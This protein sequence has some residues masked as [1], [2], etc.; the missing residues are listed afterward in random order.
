MKVL[1]LDPN[2]A[3]RAVQPPH[4]LPQLKAYLQ[5]RT[6]HRAVLLD[7]TFRKTAWRTD[8]TRTID[9]EK[10][11]LIGISCQSLNYAQA[12][13][14][15]AFAKRRSGLPILFGGVHAILAAEEVI[16]GS[17]ADMVCTGEGERTLAN[18]LDAGLD[19]RGVRGIWYRTAAG[20][21]IRNE[22]EPVI[23]DL[24][25]LPFPDWSDYDLETYFR[26]NNHH[27]PMMCSRGCPYECTYCSA[28]ALKKAL[29]WTKVRWRSVESV[30]EEIGV[31]L[32]KYAGRGFRH[33]QFDDDTFILRREFV[34]DFCR[35][36][37]ERGYDRR[38]LWAANVR[39]DL[40]TP[41]LVS[42]MKDAGCYEV[43]LGVESVDDNVRR[44][45]YKRNMSLEQIERAVSLIRGH[46]IQLHIPIIIGSPYDTVEIMERN[47]AFAKKL[48][49]ECML[50]PALMPLPGTEIR[51][52]CEDE[53][54]IEEPGF[55]RPHDMHTRPIIRT[56]YASRRDVARILKKARRYAM[57]TYAL[58]GIRRKGLRFAWDLLA[59]LVYFKPKYLLEIDNAWKF[60]LNKYNLERAHRRRRPVVSRTEEA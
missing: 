16:A 53:G 42:A 33:L 29:G 19:P 8:L 51:K 49:A 5:E 41:E 3:G 43:G 24:D 22:P 7:F 58:E 60:T 13:E 39:A 40:V 56:K 2:I 23:A 37:K 18:L 28:A 17:R 4:N 15:A 32:E 59:F 44:N 31:R 36:F 48:R 50:F 27:L 26:I 14:V 35:A 11:D 34:L 21:I 55:R 6:K 38:L 1:L 57:T 45:V 12:V 30:M 46:G 47:L 54:L 10:P 9:R 25:E 20:E 52:I